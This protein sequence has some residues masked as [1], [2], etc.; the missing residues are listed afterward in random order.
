MQ[1]YFLLYN[2]SKY[3]SLIIRLRFATA[4]KAMDTFD[5]IHH[6]KTSSFSADGKFFAT[7]STDGT[8]RNL[9]NYIAKWKKISLNLSV[10]M[11]TLWI[12]SKLTYC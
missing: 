7:A 10:V 1:G 5:T 6:M 2:Q 8:V 11:A 12:I 9:I 3:P 4:V